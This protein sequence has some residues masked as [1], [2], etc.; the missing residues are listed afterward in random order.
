[1]GRPELYTFTFAL[2]FHMLP[3]KRT[4]SP[5]FTSGRSC[6]RLNANQI[7]LKGQELNGKMKI[8]DKLSN[9]SQESIMLIPAFGNDFI[10]VSPCFRSL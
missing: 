2:C 10:F 7:N 8:S 6:R 3:E 4:H 5:A 9:K 1:M